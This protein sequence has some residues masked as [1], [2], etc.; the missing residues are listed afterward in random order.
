M[1]SGIGPT[2]ECVTKYEELKLKH[3]KRFIIYKIEGSSIIIEHE[4]DASKTYDDFLSTLK[5]CAENEPR[6]AVVDFAYST[7]DGRPQEKPIFIHWSPDTCGVKQKMS[8]ASSKAAL[9]KKLT[10][11]HKDMQINESSDLD[12][13][14]ITGKM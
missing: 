7:A 9:I 10:G 1:A 12:P 14:E 5:S 13:K 8:Y 3:S 11:I 2:D 6:F 4:A